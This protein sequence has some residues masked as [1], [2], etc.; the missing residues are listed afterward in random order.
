MICNLDLILNLS[1]GILKKF[2]MVLY[3]HFLIFL[4]PFFATQFLAHSLENTPDRV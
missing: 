1:T 3:Y 2:S 4:Y